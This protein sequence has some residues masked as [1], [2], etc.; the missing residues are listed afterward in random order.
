MRTDSPAAPAAWRLLLALGVAVALCAVVAWGLIVPGPF[1]WALHDARAYQGGIEVA[2]LLL[3]LAALQALPAPRWRLAACLL[4]A[5]LYLRRHAV[6]LPLL[7]C[8]G[9]LEFTLALGAA[10]GRCAGVGTPARS[11]DY[12]RAFLLG[13]AGWS[14]A[15]WTLSTF[16]YGTPAALRLLCL[17]LLPFALW[18]R[19]RPLSLHLYR[20]GTEASWPQRAAL[21]LLAGWGLVLFARTNTVFSFDALW[22][23]YRAEYVLS[24]DG[25]VFAPL[26]LVSPVYYFPKLYEV[27]LLPLAALGDTSVLSGMTVLLAGL[28]ALAAVRLLQRLGVTALAPRIALSALVLTLPAIANP[29]LEPKPDIVCAL[30]LLL[31][32]LHGSD[33]LQRRDTASLAW[34]LASAALALSCKLIAVPY[35][36][37]LLPALLAGLLLMRRTSTA[38]GLDAAS[39]GLPALSS[40]S[41]AARAVTRAAL[42][43]LALAVL[44]AGFVAARTWLLAGVPTVGP[45]PLF[46]LWNLLGL[47]L[48]EPA[49]TLSWALPQQWLD[50]PALCLDWLLRPQRMEHIMISWTGNVWLWLPL[51]AGLLGTAAAPAAPAASEHRWAALALIAAG[52]ILALAFGHHSRGGDGNYFIAALIAALVL[53]LALAWRRCLAPAARQALLAGVLLFAG[54]QAVYAF[55][56]AGWAPG[57][58]PLDLV[59]DRSPRDAHKLARGIVEHAG[60]G[61]VDDYLKAQPQVARVV[62][63]APFEAAMR[64]RARFE[65]VQSIAQSRPEYTA[66]LAALQG[67]QR[68]FGIPYLL[69]PRPEPGSPAAGQ[70]LHGCTP[71][72]T[73]PPGTE[74]VVQTE[75]FLLL[76]LQPDAAPSG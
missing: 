57:T 66:S 64:L 42:L 2:A 65:E 55:L 8:L 3:A 44:A 48:R 18:A 14:V 76:R 59:F 1:D 52:L 7:L 41:D 13:L 17:A 4:L 28:L 58:R 38:A 32:W 10:L 46:K 27:Y 60:L 16:G 73:A 19:A 39:G 29:A 20:R 37:V 47:Q 24:A 31:A 11:E 67:Y 54:F 49:G 51:A 35:L 25:S 33:W 36:G 69:L 15:A 30:F 34:L 40:Q 26:G 53:G 56:S 70:L 74:I 68:R 12:L 45:D 71:L 23:G 75:R 9:Y 72:D 61:P 22:Y 63:C 62:G 5:A 21:A 43:A 6:D 50:I